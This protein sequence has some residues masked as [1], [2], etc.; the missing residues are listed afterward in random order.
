MKIK[1]IKKLKVNNTLFKV[2]WDKRSGAASFCYEKREIVIGSRYEHDLLM[3]ICHELLE[4]CAIEMC[5]RYNR[6]DVSS[7]YLFSYD[8]RQHTS[9]MYMFS[10]L[11]E[12][13]IE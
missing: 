7:D 6:T 5:V 2:I 1:R 11:L 9:M 3:L 8:H 13:F 10:G 4:I 12:Q